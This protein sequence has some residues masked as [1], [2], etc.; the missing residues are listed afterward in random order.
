[1]EEDK[2]LH[3]GTCTCTSLGMRATLGRGSG[4]R[5]SSVLTGCEV[6]ETCSDWMVKVEY[7]PDF[8]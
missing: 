7:R 4:C 3:E 1:M 8:M 5:S 6:G 2:S